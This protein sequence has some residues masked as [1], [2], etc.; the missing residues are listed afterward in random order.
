MVKV[1]V[2]A[3]G[4]EQYQA[5]SITPQDVI[6]H[7]K[8]DSPSPFQVS[9]KTPPYV[10]EP[11]GNEPTWEKPERP[12]WEKQWDN[13]ETPSFIRR[14]RSASVRKTPRGIS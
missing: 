12:S 4:F 14:N 5:E 10:F 8:Q 2:I 6:I 7:P 9:H 3:T 13:Y 11:K 1:T